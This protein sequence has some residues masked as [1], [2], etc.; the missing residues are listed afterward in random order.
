MRT[1][2]C[3]CTC[4]LSRLLG[5]ASA[6]A[7]VYSRPLW[8]AAY[9]VP[10][11]GARSTGALH[12]VCTAMRAAGL[13]CAQC[14]WLC[15]GA[16]DDRRAVAQGPPRLIRHL[17]RLAGRSSDRHVP[18]D[19]LRRVK[20]RRTPAA[21]RREQTRGGR[22]IARVCPC[23]CAQPGRVVSGASLFRPT[24]LTRRRFNT[25][26]AVLEA[27]SETSGSPDGGTRGQTGTGSGCDGT[28]PF[29]SVRSDGQSERANSA[30]RLPSGQ[31]SMSADEPTFFT[32]WTQRLVTWKVL[33]NL[34]WIG[35]L[36]LFVC[37]FGDSEPMETRGHVALI[38]MLSVVITI[39]FLAGLLGPSHE[40][41]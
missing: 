28:L 36:P 3:K 21:L 30:D 19:T 34:L 23:G 32:I 33:G 24:R 14:E 29:G 16:V 18:S 2:T 39:V 1:R 13:S 22:S 4:I 9:I 12:T 6:F 31:R 7:D 37:L 17:V 41:K 40:T 10:G 11:L 26:E 27:Q 8:C 25:L 35:T 20:A 15:G 38:V 5:H